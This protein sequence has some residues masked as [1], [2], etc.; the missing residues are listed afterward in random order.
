MDSFRE[1][2]MTTLELDR[3]VETIDIDCLTVTPISWRRTEHRK[4]Q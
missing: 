2:G 1:R 4:S 3:I